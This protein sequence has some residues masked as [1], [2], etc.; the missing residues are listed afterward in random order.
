MAVETITKI[1]AAERQLK[2]AILLFFERRDP[3]AVHTL[4]GA[5]HQILYDIGKKKGIKS[6]VKD[7]EVGD[8]K[9]LKHHMKLMVE[10][11]N[12]FKHADRDAQDELQFSDL[13]NPIYLF[14][15]ILMHKELSDT[16][17]KEFSI[18]YAWSFVRDKEHY[19]RYYKDQLAIECPGADELLQN[20]DSLIGILRDPDIRLDWVIGG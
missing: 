19:D 12:Y 4:A 7:G 15:A 3:V 13:M 10:A 2:E 16:R 11:K 18:Y 17:F 1:E 5:A 8:P 20:F 14:D 9:L 6:I